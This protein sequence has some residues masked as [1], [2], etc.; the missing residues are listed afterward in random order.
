VDLGKYQEAAERIEEVSKLATPTWPD[1]EESARLLC[2]CI[3]LAG[4]DTRL[5]GAKRT[6]L[7]EQYG[8]RALAVLEG[9]TGQGKDLAARLK[10]SD[11]AP[12]RERPFVDRYRLL[13]RKLE[14]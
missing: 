7:V 4:K 12:L 9:L 11:F 6:R 3:V 13:V 10:S 2:R 5:D 8:Q 14:K 1:R